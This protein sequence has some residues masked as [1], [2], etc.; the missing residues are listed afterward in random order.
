MQGLARILAMAAT[1]ALCASAAMAQQAMNMEAMNR[2][3]FTDTPAPPL[4]GN[5]RDAAAKMRGSLQPGTG[6]FYRFAKLEAQ[7]LAR[8]AGPMEVRRWT[9][10]AL[11]G[12][13]TG[14]VNF[15]VHYYEIYRA[16]SWKALSVAQTDTGESLKVGRLGARVVSCRS[17]CSYSE[18]VFIDLP[19]ATV[20]RARTQPLRIQVS[21]M[22][23]NPTLIEIDAQ[24]VSDL[25]AK[26]G[27]EVAKYQRA[28]APA[29]VP[30]PAAV[31][32]APA[33]PAM[34]PGP[35]SPALVADELQ[36]LARLRADG[37]ITEQEFQG[38]KAKLL[39]K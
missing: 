28:S 7:P 21:G 38:L 17:G 22:A 5:A 18:E 14:E 35:A 4:G 6:D 8:E 9:L 32:A 20:E 31:Q 26:A 39:A 25:V 23:A 11:V 24:T 29:A 3:V 16:S 30:A 10:S 33:A 27:M 1:M 12:K 2:G 13:A 36:K 37:T 34:P 15:Y 19:P